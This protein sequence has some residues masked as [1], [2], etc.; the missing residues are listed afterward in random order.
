MLF[1]IQ[2][3]LDPRYKI[4][5]DYTETN[6]EVILDGLVTL[7]IEIARV[8][9]ILRLSTVSKTLDLAGEL[10]RR[11]KFSDAEVEDLAHQDLAEY[12]EKAISGFGLTESTTIDE[13][14]AHSP[15]DWRD[16]KVND[17]FKT[18]IRSVLEQVTI[19]S[20]DGKSRSKPALLGGQGP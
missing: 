17:D 1:G 7:L 3:L 5:I 11:M 10:A 18:F 2:A 19:I 12:L 16:A 4:G 20:K 9:A 14:I 13:R 15:V 8:Y 6:D